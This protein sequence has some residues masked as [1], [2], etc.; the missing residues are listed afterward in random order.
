MGCNSSPSIEEAE[1]NKQT[2]QNNN[3][4]NLETIE[5]KSDKKD[6]EKKKYNRK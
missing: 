4:E 1:N 6:E 3:K 5:P 2:I